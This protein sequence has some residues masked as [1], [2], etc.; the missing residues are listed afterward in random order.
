MAE[1]GK[2]R[3]VG[4]QRSPKGEE[5]EERVRGGVAPGEDRETQSLETSVCG[6][7]QRDGG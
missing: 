3:E 1:Q 2:R 5:G 4:R 6:G 7:R